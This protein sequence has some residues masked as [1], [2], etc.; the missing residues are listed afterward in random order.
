MMMMC[1]DLLTSL[2]AA[3]LLIGQGGLGG[4]GLAADRVVCRS[5][6]FTRLIEV[7]SLCGI[8]AGVTGFPRFRAR[9]HL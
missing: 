2:P 3:R 9:A 6:P 1:T 8:Q 5:Q 7:T 4:C